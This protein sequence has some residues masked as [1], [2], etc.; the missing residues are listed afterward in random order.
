MGKRLNH[1]GIWSDCNGISRSHK[2]SFKFYTLH[3]V[4]IITSGDTVTDIASST[5]EQFRT[6]TCNHS[7][8]DKGG[9]EQTLSMEDGC[10]DI[11]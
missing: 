7:A 9:R 6:R 2:T 10:V 5:K 11:E 1:T 3:Q 4:A 8:F